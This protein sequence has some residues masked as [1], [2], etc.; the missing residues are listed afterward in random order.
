MDS[1]A[2]LEALNFI[3]KLRD[4]DILDE[5]AVSMDDPGGKFVNGEAAI[6]SRQYAPAIK[7]KL[8]L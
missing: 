7:R 4:A 6:V 8:G 2:T 5:S 1:E 3:K